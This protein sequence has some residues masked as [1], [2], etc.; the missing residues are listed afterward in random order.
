LTPSPPG[1]H[2]DGRGVTDWTELSDHTA[3]WNR[4]VTLIVRLDVDRE[5]LDLH[6]S[7]LKL[8]VLQVSRPYAPLTR[9][10]RLRHL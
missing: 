9:C 6:A 10:E 8:T 2:S 1:V 5:T 3:T 7:E 4:Q